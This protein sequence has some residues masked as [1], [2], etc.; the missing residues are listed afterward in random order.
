[1]VYH[2]PSNWDVFLEVSNSTCFCHL[3]PWNFVLWTFYV[4]IPITPYLL[5]STCWPQRQGKHLPNMLCIHKNLRTLLGLLYSRIFHSSMSRQSNG[6]CFNIACLDLSEETE[7]SCLKQ[8]DLETLSSTLPLNLKQVYLIIKSIWFVYL[9]CFTHLPCQSQGYLWHQF[10]SRQAGSQ[11]IVYSTGCVNYVKSFGLSLQEQGF[12]SSDAF[13]YQC[14][15]TKATKQKPFPTGLQ[16]L[17]SN[18]S[19]ARWKASCD[20]Y[21]WR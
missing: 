7:P 2:I 21:K 19:M 20:D 14:Q 8:S 5:W 16:R 1:M 3:C 11:V 4:K 12:W 6:M 13:C 15:C 18:T 17:P 10:L 9:S